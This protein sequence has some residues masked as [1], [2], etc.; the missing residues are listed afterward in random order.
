MNK[1]QI[2]QLMRIYNTLLM[3]HTNGEDSFIMTDSLRA[4]E[5]LIKE[6]QKENEQTLSA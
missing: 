5:S 2:A 3:V 6:A 1:E 4:L